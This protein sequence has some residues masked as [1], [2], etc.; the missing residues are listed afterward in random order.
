MAQAAYC[1]AIKNQF[2]VYPS[3]SVCKMPPGTL[4][5]PSGKNELF[6]PKL[7]EILPWKCVTLIIPIQLLAS[8]RSDSISVAPMT[9]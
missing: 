2:I 7:T 9:F 8:D 1:N 6:N 4:P 3:S 5:K